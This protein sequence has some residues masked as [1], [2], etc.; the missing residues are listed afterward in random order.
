MKLGEELKSKV[1]T[2]KKEFVTLENG[3]EGYFLRMHSDTPALS[4]GKL[5]MI[6]LIHGGPFSSSPQDMFLTQR[7]FLLLQGYCLLV[8]NYRGTIGFG[9]TFMDSLLG[10]IGS[11][12]VEDCGD[13]T[14]KAIE[15]H[16][17]ID[18]KRVVVEGGSHGGFMTG[19]LIGHP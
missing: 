18:P 17:V 16:S 6:T 14:K 11:R 4:N 5:P 2:I 3:A 15:M 13:L 8:V 12:D 1:D 19:W 9:K 10:H 7:N